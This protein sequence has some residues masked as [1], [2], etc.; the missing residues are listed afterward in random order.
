M[1]P[2]DANRFM[3]ID[4]V[5]SQNANFL[6]ERSTRLRMTDAHIYLLSTVFELG[7]TDQ[8]SDL[9]TFCTAFIV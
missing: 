7:L 2:Q 1:G 8:M 3:C 5:Q 4:K 9:W 6:Y